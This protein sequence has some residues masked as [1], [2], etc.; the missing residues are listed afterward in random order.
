MEVKIIVYNCLFTP[1]KLVQGL[2]SAINTNMV[3]INTVQIEMPADVEL[4]KVPPSDKRQLLIDYDGKPQEKIEIV[5]LLTYLA[6]SVNFHR[7]KYNFYSFIV[8]LKI[9]L[10]GITV[11]LELLVLK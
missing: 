11:D 3:P 5:T 2:K 1:V 6:Q 10:S 7:T 9:T 4:S 8:K